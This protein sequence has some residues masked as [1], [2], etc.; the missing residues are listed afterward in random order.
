[1]PSPMSDDD[2]L[3]DEDL[4]RIVSKLYARREE[5]ARAGQRILHRYGDWSP[6]DTEGDPPC[7]AK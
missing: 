1:M 7:P 4:K 6:H 3:T 2:E 5:F